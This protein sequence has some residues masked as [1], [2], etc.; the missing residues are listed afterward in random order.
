MDKRVVTNLSSR[1]WETADYP[2]NVVQKADN[3]LAAL[4]ARELWETR[5]RLRQ[6]TSYPE[7]WDKRHQDDIATDIKAFIDLINRGIIK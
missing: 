2:E 1:G 5:R 4:M 6:D 7:T 3:R